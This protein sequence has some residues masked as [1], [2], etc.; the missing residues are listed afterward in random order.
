MYDFRG[1]LIENV[2]SYVDVTVTATSTRGAGGIVYAMRNG[3]IRN[4]ANHGSVSSTYSTG[5]IVGSI[6]G[7]DVT[8]EGCYNTGNISSTNSGVGGIVGAATYNQLISDCYNTGTI[9]GKQYVGGLV[10]D[11]RGGSSGSASI[12][13]LSP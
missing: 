5:G 2:T 3:A 12:R 11:F 7:W 8:I 4:C 9:T 10:G 1:S 13:A 6:Y